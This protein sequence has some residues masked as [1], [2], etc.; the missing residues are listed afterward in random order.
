[1]LVCS[2][3]SFFSFQV[4]F[5]LVLPLCVLLSISFIILPPSGVC[6]VLFICLFP[7]ACGHLCVCLVSLTLSDPHSLTLVLCLPSCVSE[8]YFSLLTCPCL[9]LCVSVTSCFI[10][11]APYLM[12][13]M[14]SLASLV[15]S[16]RFVPD[17]FPPVV[18]PLLV[19]K[20]SDCFCLLSVFMLVLLSWRLNG[21]TGSHQYF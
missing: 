21:S 7:Q 2:L 20:S 14:F 19:F 12:R 11:T 9:G 10:L 4:L 18:H 6:L 17:V 13:V 16:V 15:L 1:M 3:L 8:F 5:A